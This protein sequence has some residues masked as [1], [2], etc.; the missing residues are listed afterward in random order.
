M[1]QT[2]HTVTCPECRE[3]TSVKIET[4]LR[5]VA[6]TCQQCHKNID[7]RRIG[8]QSVERDRQTLREIRREIEHPRPKVAVSLDAA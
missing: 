7:L 6:F 8:H 1:S 4:M 5:C 3:R 2:E